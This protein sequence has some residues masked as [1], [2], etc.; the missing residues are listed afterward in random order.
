MILRRTHPRNSSSLVRDIYPA[1]SVVALAGF[2][3]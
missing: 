2:F 3:S 1:Y